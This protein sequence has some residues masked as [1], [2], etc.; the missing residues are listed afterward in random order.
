MQSKPAK[1][2]QNYLTQTLKSI[3]A[4]V[5]LLTLNKQN[6]MYT[7]T[8]LTQQ[9]PYFNKLGFCMQSNFLNYYFHLEIGVALHIR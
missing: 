5:T 4:W 8:L 7:E 2:N 6:Y 1:Q 3:G 9:V